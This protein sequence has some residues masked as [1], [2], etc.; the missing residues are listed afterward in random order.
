MELR[1]NMMLYSNLGNKNSDVGHIKC[2]CKSHL[3]RM[4]QVP[5]PCSKSWPAAF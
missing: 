1:F 5:Q 3:A 4:P 2:S